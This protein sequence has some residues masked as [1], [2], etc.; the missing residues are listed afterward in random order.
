MTKST[1]VGLCGDL[2]KINKISKNLA[3]LRP[4]YPRA[5]ELSGIIPKDDI[6]EAYDF[7]M[8]RDPY[9]RHNFLF[10]DLNPKLDHP[11]PFRMNYESWLIS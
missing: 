7:V 1:E 8:T 11:S 6:L 5:T 9:N 2:Q 10:V 4:P 3:K